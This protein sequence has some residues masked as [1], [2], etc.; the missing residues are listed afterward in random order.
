MY[1]VEQIKLVEIGVSIEIKITINGIN[2]YTFRNF[3][4]EDEARKYLEEH[5]LK[6][7]P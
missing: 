2:F 3:E 7:T 1:T 5:K 4:T 6:E